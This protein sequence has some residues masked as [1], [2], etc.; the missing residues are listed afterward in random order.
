MLFLIGLPNNRWIDIHENL[1]HLPHPVAKLLGGSL[2]DL[3]G[4]LQT[5]LDASVARFLQENECRQQTPTGRYQR[6]ARVA[7]GD[8]PKWSK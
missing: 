8:R 4:N 1:K 3:V 6:D 7:V 2:T 5:Y